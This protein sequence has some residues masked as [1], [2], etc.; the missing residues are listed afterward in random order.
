MKSLKILGIAAV[1]AMSFTAFAASSASAT[2]LEVAGV[3]QNKQVTLTASLLPGTKMVISRT[4]GSLANECSS[5]HAHGLTTLFTGHVVT[6]KTTGHTTL[7][8]EAGQ[9]PEDGM[10][11]SGC[12][13]PVTVHD[14]GTFFITYIEGTTDGTVFSE[15]KSITVGS[16]FG[17]LN[18]TSGEGV[19]LGR[20]TGKAAG[21]R[22]TI[23]VNAVTNCGFLVPSSF[24]KGT[25]E[26]TSPEGLGVSA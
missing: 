4:D 25:Y 9:K 17:T 19:D 24:W 11:F 21:E 18:C 1:V 12:T 23:D 3:T 5:S 10:S 6:G 16:P 14:P 26:I 13:R 22:A 2:T 8:K 15:N 7:D 20:L